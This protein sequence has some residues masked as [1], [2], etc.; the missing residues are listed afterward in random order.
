MRNETLS[1]IIGSFLGAALIVAGL[2]LFARSV[3]VAHQN[4]V[5]AQA[6]VAA[7]LPA[8]TD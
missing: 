1:R 4:E 5:H 8:A 7:K 6:H 3:S 2:A